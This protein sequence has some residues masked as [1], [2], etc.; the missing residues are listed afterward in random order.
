MDLDVYAGA[1]TRYYIGDWDRVL[2]PGG[3]SA[4]EEVMVTRIGD[5][6]HVS[7]NPVEVREA[8]LEWR[9]WMNGEV[10]LLEEPLDWPEERDVPYFTDHPTLEGYGALQLWA[11][12]AEQPDLRRP[13]AMPSDWA[14]DPALEASS[15]DEFQSDFPNLLYSVDIYLPVRVGEVFDAID[16]EEDDTRFGS[17]PVLL[18]ELEELNARTWRA[19][20]DTIRGWRSAAPAA[21]ADLEALARYGYATIRSVASKAAEFGLPVVIDWPSELTVSTEG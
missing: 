15:D 1:L 10:D 6:G 5:N 20:D 11:A 8:I 16:F 7:P 19:D 14:A 3:G 2:L 9:E 12:Y 17:V 13:V 21:G 18:E 4:G